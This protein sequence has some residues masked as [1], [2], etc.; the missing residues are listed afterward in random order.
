MNWV[1]IGLSAGTLVSMAIIFSYILGWAN[2][3]FHV[4]TDPRVEAVMDE[5]PGANCGGCGYVGCYEYA[6]AVA[7]NG[8]SVSKCTVGGQNCANALAQIM[9]VEVEER[10]P[11]R[12]IV[13]CAATYDERLKKSE[14]KGEKRCLA[15]NLVADIQGCT[16]G[17]LGFGDCQV[18]CDYDAIHVFNGLAVVNYDK[19]VGCGACTKVCPRNIISMVPFKAE[20]I[21]AVTCC[22]KDFGKDVKEVCSVGCTGCKACSKATNLI[23]IED[24][25]PVID[26]ERYTADAME[27]FVKAVEKCPR[28]GL[29][30]VGKPSAEDVEAVK[31]EEL[32]TLAEANFDTTVDKTGWR[33]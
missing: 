22:N 27:G 12:P 25:L 4:E 32:P 14:Y 31:D 30:F 11:Y 1:T 5:L 20:R 21:L 29:V 2:K 18:A 8:E 24:N 3:A 15:A 10:Y 7:T 28:K 16:Y 6:E 33:G 23:A 13:H 17:C 26:D 9:G 19:C